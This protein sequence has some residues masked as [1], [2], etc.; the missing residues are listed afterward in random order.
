MPENAD[1]PATQPEVIHL[2]RPWGRMAQYALNVHAS[3]KIVTVEAGAELSL[4]YHHQ[5]AEL[6]VMLDDGL[7]VEVDGR[8]W[9]ARSGEEVWIPA[10]ATHR[11]RAPG[12]GGRLLEVAFGHFDEA[13]IVRLSDRY[14]RTA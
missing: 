8:S 1:A 11:L 10:G 13:D 4:Q 12:A 2:T 14:G 5:R 6:W 9:E 3:V 7:H